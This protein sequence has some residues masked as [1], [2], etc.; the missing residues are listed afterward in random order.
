MMNYRK[1]T[2]TEIKML[3]SQGCVSETWNCIEV[4][5]DFNP[6]HYRNVT[7]SGVVRLGATNKIFYRDSSVG[8]QSGIYNATIHNCI[9]GDDVYIAKVSNYIANYYI[10]DG[11]FIENVNRINATGESTYGNG[12]QV[13]VLNESGGR[14]VP[15]C[16]QLSAHVAYFIAMYRHKPRLINSLRNLI[17]EYAQ[18]QRSERGEIGK[19]S[20]IINSGDIV[21]VKIGECARIDGASRL[22][23]GTIVSTQAAPVRVGVNVIADDFIFMSGA[24]VD[25]G[26]VMTRVF[27]GQGARVARLFSAH[28]SLFFANCTCENGEAASVFAGPNTVSTH[29]SS[30]LIAGMF[31]FLNAG[32]GSNQSNHM[33]KLGPIHQGIVERGS[34]TTSDSYILWPAHIGAFSLV[35]GRHVGHPDTSRLPFSYLIEKSG[36]SYLVPGVNLKSVGTIRDS[37]KWPRRDRRTGH[38]HLDQIN[39]NLLS[40]Y[41]VAKMIEGVNLLQSIKETS[42]ETASTYSYQGM[43]IDARALDNGIKYYQYAIDKFMG[44]SVI[45]R[46]KDTTDIYDANLP[47]LLSAIASAGEGEWIDV[48]GL[49]APKSEITRLCDDIETGVI[50]D[51]ESINTRLREMHL[52]YY[53]M[54]WN[55]VVEHFKIWWGKECSE[56]TTTDL[57]AIIKRWHESVITLDKLLYDDARK[58][59]SLEKKVGFGLDGTLQC[60]ERDFEQVRGEFERDPFVKMVL[61]HINDKTALGNEMLHRLGVEGSGDFV[62]ENLLRYS[63][64]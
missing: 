22:K 4:S 33:Y 46:L 58:E 32:S 3:K 25:E 55:W 9:I 15:I 5:S 23:N 64:F 62:R 59:F 48:A 18:Q 54:E 50:E 41:T 13:S 37:K 11:V 43:T 53:N 42:G 47:R 20:I 6:H 10:A 19:S 36:K 34:K 30:L 26:A 17:I 56:L 49:I 21:D 61:A 14:E 39:Y 44:N 38:D 8:C 24:E 40:P 1:L 63:S 12:V 16:D 51:V 52:C 29:K 35:M 28:D 7:F 57:V 60:K 27:V 45:S 31:S 2:A